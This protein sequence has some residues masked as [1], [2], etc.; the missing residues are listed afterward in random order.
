MFSLVNIRFTTSQ[1][2]RQNMPGATMVV[3]GQNKWLEGF[4]RSGVEIHVLL[5][6][7]AQ[8]HQIGP[9]PPR[10]PVRP[11][12][13]YCSLQYNDRMILHSVS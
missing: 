10:G 8:Y 4:Y 13:P 7:K 9:V 11:R 2:R 6:K 5:R 12:G 3:L 1:G